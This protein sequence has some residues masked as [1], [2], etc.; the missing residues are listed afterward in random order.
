MTDAADPRDRY[1]FA[2]DNT[3]GLFPEAL[4]TFVAANEGF[5]PSYGEDGWTAAATGSIRDLFEAECDV[6]FVFNGT[7]AN[8]LALA[9]LCQSY[10]SVICHR[11]AHVETDE[12]GAPELFSHGAKL[13]LGEGEGGRLDPASVERLATARADLHYPKPR[14]V[15][16]TQ[17]TELGTVYAPDQVAAVGDV[18]R[19]LGLR[20]HVD[21]ARLANAL[22]SA[23]TR[24]AGA[25]AA[26]LT[27]RAGVDVL[28]LGGTKAGMGLGEAVVFFDRA[29][30]EE[31][32]WRCKQAGQL[33]SKM[34]FVSAPWSRVLADGSWLRHAAHA[35]AMAQRLADGLAAIDGVELVHP[36]EANEVFVSLDERARQALRA[37]RW[38][39]YDFVGGGTRLVCSWATTE[40]AV[41]QL[42]ADVRTGPGG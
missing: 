26:D 21:G 2:S 34:R 6:Y 22:V 41:D 28:S 32:A 40:A 9:T 35:N 17:S 23:R 38:V 8:A 4:E 31:F 16:I 20:L 7:A 42:V 19:R 18:C 3:A 25:S 36:T 24:E 15:T 33:A 39:A 30:G 13:L 1:D 27:W 29:L 14:A 10:H 37:G 11:A 5:V 12:C